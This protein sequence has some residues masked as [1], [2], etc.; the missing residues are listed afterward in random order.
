MMTRFTAAS[1]A[2]LQTMLSQPGATTDAVIVASEANGRYAASWLEEGPG[3]TDLQQGVAL[4][5]RVGTLTAPGGC[6]A[7]L[8]TSA[9]LSSVRNVQLLPDG[10]A[11]LI[12]VQSKGPSGRAESSIVRP[13]GANSVPE[14]RTETAQYG[15]TISAA[16][17]ASG[18]SAL[19]WKN[20]VGGGPVS[21]IRFSVRSSTGS[22][23]TNAQVVKPWRDIGEPSLGI[24]PRGEIWIVWTRLAPKGKVDVVA[25]SVISNGRLAHKRVLGHLYDLAHGMSPSGSSG[26]YVIG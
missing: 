2:V 1:K 15:P 13:D 16:G 25:A 19:A 5:A 6:C 14:P 20:L 18:A 8:V 26:P 17:N 11:Q 7:T 10:N 24:S 22:W 23:S 21:E 4:R 12:W 9:E 3:S